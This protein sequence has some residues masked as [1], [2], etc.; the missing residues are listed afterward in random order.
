MFPANSIAPP[1]LT[2]QSTP[3]DSPPVPQ[4]ESDSPEPQPNLMNSLMADDFSQE[5]GQFV[6]SLTPHLIELRRRVVVIVAAL[7]VGMLI[8]LALAQPILE[9]LAIP[10]GGLNKLQAI[11]LT[12][13]I[14]VYMRVGL[15]FGAILAMPV[16]VYE[17]V[18]FIAPGLLPHEKRLLLIS[19]PVIFLSFIVGAAF[20]YF[21]MLPVAIPFLADFGGVQG[22]F[23]ISSYVSFITRVVFWVGVAFETPLVI[24]VLARIGL[25]TP[26][27]LIKGWRFAV[28]GIAVAAALITPTPDP[29]NMG[30]VM[31]PLLALYGL[32]II[33]AKIMYRQRAANVAAEPSPSS[34]PDQAP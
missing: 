32:S 17:L 7:T 29:V 13:S 16:I 25:V 11:E 33:L 34:Q 10:I 3:V 18:A 22:N 24:A 8:G 5:L 19:L 1:G 2:P 9:I 15:M 21:V 12:E 27:Q 26:Q 31:A 14:G 30:I 23:R 4:P 6:S 20:A 28:V